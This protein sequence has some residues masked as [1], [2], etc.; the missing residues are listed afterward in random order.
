MKDLKINLSISS[1]YYKMILDKLKS[2]GGNARLV[3]G[4]VR[5]AILNI[6]THD[7]DIAT[8]LLPEQVEITLSDLPKIK[9]I[10]HAKKFGTIFI[11]YEDEHFEITTLRNDIQTDGRRAIVSFTEDFE[12]D[13][14]RRDF[15]VNAL[16]YC[17][18][19]NK[20]YDYFNGM[21][22]LNDRKIIFIGDPH[23]RIQEDFLRI[24]RFFRF[25]STY[26]KIIDQNGVKACFDLKE[27][28]KI[29]SKE[30]IKIEMDKIINSQNVNILEIMKQNSIL[31]I[32]Y[33]YP[34]DL[35]YIREFYEL[36]KNF[37][38][39]FDN[40]YKY[41]IYGLIFYKY[42]YSQEYFLEL[43]F[44][45]KD[46][47]ILY[48]IIIT[49]KEIIYSENF[50]Y[51][52]IWFEQQDFFQYFV[53]IAI[54]FKK[55]NIDSAKKII[56]KYKNLSLPIFPIS[57]KDLLEFKQYDCLKQIG[58]DLEFL[59]NIWIQSDFYLNKEAL[60]NMIN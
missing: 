13:A 35:E 18:F 21:N 5:D 54:L 44:T 38:I 46:T 2:Q 16:S 15:T 9:I 50:F 37:S 22:H 23:K 8:T 49:I 4:V 31:E 59:K 43:K 45:K 41:I 48:Q 36:I 33:N 25:S 12:I 58:K 6:S 14:S 3:G 29:L 39:K 40:N 19:E 42:N 47:K 26:A 30:R 11:R 1:K 53:I 52:N 55:I 10:N 56:S 7:I 32:L 17:P 28:L 34:F 20:I 57:A 60:L 27:G 24:L 51:N